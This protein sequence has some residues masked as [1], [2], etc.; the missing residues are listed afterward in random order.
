MFEEFKKFALRGNVIDLAVGIMIGAAFGK[1]VTVLV[2]NVLMPPI[3]LIIGG[4]NFRD[5]A[6]TLKEASGDQPAV[7]IGYGEFLQA[8]FDF[9]IIALV[10]FYLVRIINSIGKKP[11]PGPVLPVEP[12]REQ[13]LLEE[14]RDL[15]KNK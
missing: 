8:T 11:E 10:I 2:N 6:I 7:L 14:I 9:L 4:V 1:I 15:L 13:V 5:L 3:G 12:P